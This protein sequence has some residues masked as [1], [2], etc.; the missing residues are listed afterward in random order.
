MEQIPEKKELSV[1]LPVTYIKQIYNI[2]LVAN[3]RATWHPDELI[4]V[5]V[6]I[7]EL[8]TILEKIEK[9]SSNEE[10]NEIPKEEDEKPKEDG[11]KPKEE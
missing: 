7:K 4:P 2:L 3:N 6:T 11:E 1:S 9:E 10:E 8:K 5:G